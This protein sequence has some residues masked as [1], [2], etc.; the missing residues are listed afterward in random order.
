MRHFTTGH[1]IARRRFISGALISGVSTLAV[2]GLAGGSRITPASAAMPQ[3]PLL[4]EL[5][6][7]QGCSSCPP[8]D[9]ALRELAQ[10]RIDLLPL[11]FHVTYWDRL[12][13][14]DPFS[15]D[16]ATQRQRLYAA[17]RQD[18]TIYTPQLIVEGVTD[19]VGS[20]RAGVARAILRAMG[21]AVAATA[22]SLRRI[23]DDVAID[24]GDGSG[25]GMVYV[26]GY[27]AEHTT[28]VGRGENGGRTLVEANIVRGFVAAGLWNG[29]AL[30]LR[31]PRPAG[32]KLAA[33]VQAVDGRI[34]GAARET[35]HAS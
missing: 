22:V 14:R 6:T 19:V 1:T 11:A 20:D 8:A 9:A 7:S 15:L 34:L 13:W 10:A 35:P 12:G 18:S 23:N 32:E 33:F 25:A 27:D 26:V 5:F 31:Q 16:A 17:Q 2:A 30:S 28:P 24:I 29:P 21:E 3:R 4:L